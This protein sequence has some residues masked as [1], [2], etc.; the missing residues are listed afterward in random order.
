M[1]EYVPSWAR[2]SPDVDPIPE[3]EKYG[4]GLDHDHEAARS[5]PAYSS[6]RDQTDTT[7]GDAA[8]E[9]DDTPDL[10][11]WVDLDAV[12]PR[13]RDDLK[14]GVSAPCRDCRDDD[15]DRARACYQLP[16]FVEPTVWYQ[17]A[18]RHGLRVVDVTTLD[19]AI[20]NKQDSERAAYIAPDGL[21]AKV[22]QTHPDDDE[23]SL[24]Y[25]TV[26]GPAG[27]VEMFVD[28]LLDAVVHI[29]RELRA[30]ALVDVAD[31]AQEQGKRVDDSDRLV[32]RDRAA[33][34]VSHLPASGDLATN[35]RVDR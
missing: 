26:R 2:G 1:S 32:D 31:A 30:P 24:S 16:T 12:A 21:F 11:E 5:R 25:L 4:G 9:K 15:A 13:C 3:S 27:A 33:D 6:L 18:D 35:G 8:D 29:K 17:L 14:G 10:P 22:V 20:L 19:D 7:G 34:V 28:D 23:T